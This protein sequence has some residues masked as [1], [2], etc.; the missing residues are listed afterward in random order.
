MKGSVLHV[1]KI[2]LHRYFIIVLAFAVTE[3]AVCSTFFTSRWYLGLLI[4][5]L[6]CILCIVFLICTVRLPKN[7]AKIKKSCLIVCLVFAL[8]IYTWFNLSSRR[9]V[10]LPEAR[11]ISIVERSFI[12]Y[13]S[14]T[15]ESPLGKQYHVLCH[16]NSLPNKD[17]Q[18]SNVYYE[19]KFKYSYLPPHLGILK[20]IK[21]SGA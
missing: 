7:D 11:C 13:Y 5:F 3:I 20:S 18:N 16:E 17:L 8:H 4:S 14:I 12:G 10:L 21:N 9:D 2:I 15:I 19:V 1:T 6:F